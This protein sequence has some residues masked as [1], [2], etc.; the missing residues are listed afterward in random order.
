MFDRERIVTGCSAFLVVCQLF[1]SSGFPV[2]LP[3]YVFPGERS[4]P[5]LGRECSFGAQC[6]VS[7]DGFTAQCQCL[8]KCDDFGDSVGSDP[9]CGSDGRDYPNTCEM[10][11]TGCEEMR[12]VDQKLSGKCGQ[13]FLFHEAPL[14]SENVYILLKTCL[15]FIEFCWA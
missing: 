9:L 2:V 13:S 6:V 15:K 11:K 4:D 12:R 7:F 8:E 10:L 5:C 3:C 1:L 14:V